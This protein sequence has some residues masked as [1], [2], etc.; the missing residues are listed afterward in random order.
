MS[1]V[2]VDQNRSFPTTFGFKATKGFELLS[3]PPPDRNVLQATQ[4]QSSRSQPPQ[5]A[6]LHTK[7]KVPGVL[8]TA[9]SSAGQAAAEHVGWK[10]LLEISR[11][12]GASGVVG[13]RNPVDE[14]ADN[15][16]CQIEVCATAHTNASIR[17]LVKSVIRGIKACQEPEK[18]QDGMGGTYFFVNE[19]GRKAAILKP[20][21]EEPLAPNNPKGY[22][23]RALG[24]PGW[25]P[26]VRVGEAA[27]REVAAYLL[28]HEGFAKVPTSVLVRARHPIFC[29]NNRMSSVRASTAELAGATDAPNG[30]LP[31]KLGSLQEFVSHECDTSEMGP[32]RFSVKDVHRIGILDIRLFNTDRHAGNMLVRVSRDS[33]ANLKSRIADAQYELIPIDHGFCLPET[34]EAPY[35]EWLHW[36]QTMLPFSEEELQYIKNLDIEADKEL[37]R[38][39]LPN[40]R[41]E[42]LRVMELATTLLKKGAEAGLTL[43]EIASMMSRPF[44]DADEEPSQLETLCSEARAMLEVGMCEEESSFGSDDDIAEEEMEGEDDSDDGDDTLQ[45]DLTQEMDGVANMMTASGS[46]RED[47]GMMFDL[48]DYAAGKRGVTYPGPRSPSAQSDGSSLSSV[49]HMSFGLSNTTSTGLTAM[50]PRMDVPTPG[51]LAV[52]DTPQLTSFSRGAARSVHVTDGFLWRRMKNRQAQGKRHRKPKRT[53]PQAYPPPVLSQAPV[54]GAINLGEMDEDAWAAFMYAVDRKIDSGIREDRWRQAKSNAPGGVAM[55]CPRF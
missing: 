35:F 39:E 18:A 5:S 36:P 49:E 33:S 45:R 37:L 50:T 11:N 2:V 15:K 1:A 28:D 22:V 8:Q 46:S 30:L 40:L 21:D 48:D 20:C 12:S 51:L 38:K 31:M 10:G 19:N 4:F 32:S 3:T 9:S 52:R 25:K 47:D 42:C 14:E 44:G 43:F 13:M 53:S 55:S 23:G 54:G 27:M 17:R 16:E 24:D 34:L 29:Y 26:T 41:P 6:E 7:P